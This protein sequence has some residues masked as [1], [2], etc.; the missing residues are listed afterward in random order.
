MREYFLD[1][2][3]L[4]DPCPEPDEGIAMIF[5]LPP[6]SQRSMS[7]SNTRFRSRAQPMR[8]GALCAGAC[9]QVCAAASCVGFGT[10]CERSPGTMFG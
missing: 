9:S 8:T 2:I 3:G 1:H 10:T 4:F 6:H 7:R 5:K